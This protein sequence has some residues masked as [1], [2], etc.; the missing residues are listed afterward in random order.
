M[1]G[2]L[3]SANSPAPHLTG[4]VGKLCGPGHQTVLRQDPVR[5]LQA[6]SAVCALQGEHRRQ[7]LENRAHHHLQHCHAAVRQVRERVCEHAD[8]GGRWRVGSG[9]NAARVSSGGA[10][11]SASGILKVDD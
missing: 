6:P 2:L 7:P 11:C 5:L 3:G 1:E 10:W 9:H 4:L 8:A